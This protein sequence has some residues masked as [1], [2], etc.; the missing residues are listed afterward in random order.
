[1][2]P[3]EKLAYW[4]DHVMKFGG[5]HLRPAS[6]DLPLFKMFML[7]VF[8]FLTAMLVAAMYAAHCM[9]NYCCQQKTKPK[10]D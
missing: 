7:D 3:K 10:K 6:Q 9:V 5:G 4:V 2:L 8:A 1:M